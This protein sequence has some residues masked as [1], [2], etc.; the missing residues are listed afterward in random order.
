M[1]DYRIEQIDRHILKIIETIQSL[2]QLSFMM[3]DKMNIESAIS[4]L[5]N[6]KNRLED[7][8]YT[9]IKAFNKKGEQQ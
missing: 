3:K 4:D 7:L 6:E 1:L 5:I 2:E 9:E 8:I